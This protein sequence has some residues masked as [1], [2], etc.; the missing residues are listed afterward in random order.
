MEVVDLVVGRLERL[1][2]RR[3][4]IDEGVGG[5]APELGGEGAHPLEHA[6]G[7][8]GV[9]WA[10]SPDPARLAMCS[11]RSPERSSSGTIRMMARA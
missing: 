5:G 6:R 8:V 2:G 3:I 1:A 9:S 7:R 10:A 11:A 4:A